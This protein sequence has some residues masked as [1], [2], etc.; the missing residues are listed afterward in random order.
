MH[1]SCTDLVQ[2]TGSGISLHIL[3]TRSGTLFVRASPENSTS[4]TISDRA[5]EP[6]ASACGPFQFQEGVVGLG[7][8]G[9]HPSGPEVLEVGFKDLAGQLSCVWTGYGPGPPV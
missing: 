5:L 3:P 8:C 1:V 9:V 7:K 4:K 6:L 2:R